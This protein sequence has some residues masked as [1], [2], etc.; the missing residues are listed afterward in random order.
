MQIPL[1]SAQIRSPR[2]FKSL[3]PLLKLGEYPG[4][5]LKEISQENRDAKL[6]DLL[7]QAVEELEIS[8]LSDPTNRSV[9]DFIGRMIFSHEQELSRL[10]NG[11]IAM[12]R[13][14]QMQIL[15][16]RISRLR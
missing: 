10:S 8:N 11:M 13:V 16:K 3:R 2:E 6:N 1:N 4:L 15:Q 5:F 12:V 9:R 7:T 14:Q